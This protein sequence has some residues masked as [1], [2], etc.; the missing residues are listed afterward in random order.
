MLK[1][2]ITG[3]IG[4]GKSIVCRLFGF[5]GIPVYD[6]DLRAK[7]VMATNAELRQEL[8]QAFG[9]KTFT[10]EGLNRTWLASQVFPDAAKL[11]VLNALVHPHVKQDFIDW[12]AAQQN[13]S[14]V[15]KEAAL[16]YET[17]AHKQ[18]EKMIVVSAPLELRLQRLALRDKHR[19]QA[20]LERIIAKQLPEEEKTR[21]ADYIIYNDDTQLVIPQVIQLHTQL[22]ALAE[23]R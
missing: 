20:D 15:I 7:Q 2:G 3:G 19:T 21:R 14:Y 18:V 9:E 17:E 12:S 6:S 22:I 8:I 23:K 16:M 10:P 11:A 1:V 5:M 13:V 4:T